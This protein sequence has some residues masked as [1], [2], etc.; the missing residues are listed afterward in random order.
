MGAGL[1]LP[2]SRKLELFHTLLHLTVSTPRLSPSS[3]TPPSSKLGPVAKACL[4]WAWSEWPPL[5]GWGHAHVCQ[6]RGG[7]K[8]AGC[9]AGT[10]AGGKE[11]GGG[12]PLLAHAWV[13]PPPSGGRG[14]LVGRFEGAYLGFESSL[15]GYS[16]QGSYNGRE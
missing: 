13:P 16:R 7:G 9:P 10:T 11:R 15:R 8:P 3:P 4:I 1:V 12:A 6:Q 14:A 5:I 2:F